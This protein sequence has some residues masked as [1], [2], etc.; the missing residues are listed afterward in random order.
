MHSHQHLDEARHAEVHHAMER[1]QEPLVRTFEEAGAAD[2]NLA[3]RA[4]AT[5]FAGLIGS[6]VMFGGD[7]MGPTR[8]SPLP[9]EP[10]ARLR[11][12]ISLFLGGYW[13]LAQDPQPPIGRD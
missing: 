8:E 9:A 11:L 10:E 5:L 1:L 7:P 13:A 3:P 6:L 12:A 2:P 4:A